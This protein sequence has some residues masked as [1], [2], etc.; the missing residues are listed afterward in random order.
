MYRLHKSQAALGSGLIIMAMMLGLIM[1]GTHAA[2]A[3]A[4]PL[5][6]NWIKGANMVGYGPDPYKIANQHDAIASWAATGANTI[7][8]GP[9]WFMDTPSSTSIAPNAESAR[10][11][12]N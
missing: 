2:H 12:M 5:P 9:R 11:P 10:P 7:A 4:T 3:Q 6:A 1:G 8:Y